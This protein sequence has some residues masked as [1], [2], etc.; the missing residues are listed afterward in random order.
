VEDKNVWDPGIDSI[1]T[2]VLHIEEK[3]HKERLGKG[4]GVLRDNR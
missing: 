2:T 4:G 3:H 1:R